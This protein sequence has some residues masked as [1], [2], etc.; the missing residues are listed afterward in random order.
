[1]NQWI[2]LYCLLNNK[3]KIGNILSLLNPRYFYEETPR[4][5]YGYIRDLVKR[6]IT[7]DFSLV[8][9]KFKEDVLNLDLS[10]DTDHYEE[11]I[12]NLRLNYV[13]SEAKRIAQTIL[14]KKS[15]DEKSFTKYIN[16]FIG[17]I[18]RNK[19]ENTH[20]SAD[21]YEE[22]VKVINQEEEHVSDI[23]Y[24]IESLDEHTT[25][26]WPGEYTLIA[27]RPSM[28]KSGVISHIA[29]TNALAGKNVVL[30]SLEM[31]APKIML[32]MLSSLSNTE[33]WKLK[34]IKRRSEEEQKRV[35]ESAERLRD[36][37]IIIDTTPNINI[38]SMRSV[39][40]K[41]KLQKN[42]IDCILVDYIQLMDGEGFNDNNRV[43][44]ISKGLKGLSMQF[45]AGLIAGSQLS[46]LCEQREDKR[47][48]LSDLR[49][50]GS[51]EQ[52]ADLVMM[53]YRDHYYKYNPNHEK[54]L[55]VLIRKF[56]NGEV[57]KKV[58]EYD[59][60]KQLLRSINYNGPLGQIAKKFEYS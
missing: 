30:F 27:G 16:E 6:G 18:S 52:D 56:R 53:L 49:D 9:S 45:E 1:M 25:G 58:I 32:R 3:D 54:I 26:I 35:L 36:S 19:D 48:I 24:G 38:E 13:N 8:K 10:V 59:M 31:P 57:G 40:H 5:V 34:R 28:G 29:M 11:Y 33:L 21:I 44:E 17:S 60:K 12:D 50:S 2:V 22:L 41:I 23:K 39:L 20:Y 47:P 7:P 55:E 43:S 4:E 46:R 15:I 14:D 37:G 42:H 51:L